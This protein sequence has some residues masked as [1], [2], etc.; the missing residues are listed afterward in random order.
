MAIYSLQ[1]KL[2]EAETAVATLL[3]VFNARLTATMQ[4]LFV[5]SMAGFS[6]ADIQQT[7][8]DFI[9]QTGWTRDEF[10]AGKMPVLDEFMGR[11]RENADASFRI[12]HQEQ[13]R[14]E[15]SKPQVFDQRRATEVSKAILSGAKEF[16]ERD[17]IRLGK[18]P[19]SK[20]AMEEFRREYRALKASWAGE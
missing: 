14:I 20:E 12:A 18:N 6:D 3:E 16:I 10:K 17:K 5:D 4:N 11:L 13:M 9:G 15:K 2:T 1:T 19:H 7:T 8:R